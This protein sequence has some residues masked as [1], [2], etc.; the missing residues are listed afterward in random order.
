MAQPDGGATY[1]HTVWFRVYQRA[2]KNDKARVRPSVDHNRDPDRYAYA[3]RY[4]SV[5]RDQLGYQRVHS[6]GHSHGYAQVGVPVEDDLVE[7]IAIQL[8]TTTGAA[9]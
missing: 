7:C 5:G 2:S 6:S 3:S 9:T 8:C 4:D 1:S